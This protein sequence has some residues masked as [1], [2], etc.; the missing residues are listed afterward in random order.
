MVSPLSQPPASAPDDIQARLLEKKRH[1][2]QVYD[3][4]VKLNTPELTQ[5]DRLALEHEK[6]LLLIPTVASALK[7]K[8]ADLEHLKSRKS[9]PDPEVLAGENNEAALMSA[10][11]T[12]LATQS[13]LEQQLIANPEDTSLRRQVADVAVRLAAK[14]LALKQQQ[15]EVLKRKISLAHHP[16]TLKKLLAGEEHEVAI[17]QQVETLTSEIQAINQ[18]ILDPGLHNEGYASL[19]TSLVHAQLKSINLQ[20]EMKQ[21]NIHQLDLRLKP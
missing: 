16:E 4:L 1:L 20:L 13:E 17:L 2:Q 6:T 11:V 5:P 19:Y 21:E 8:E 15:V 7:L 3:A 9:P 18:Q 10:K 14:E 12:L